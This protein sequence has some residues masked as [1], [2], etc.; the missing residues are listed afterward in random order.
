[1]NYYPFHLG[2]YAVHTR[3]L[4]LLEDLAYRRLL[5]LYYTRERPIPAE[6][7]SVCRLIGMRENEAEV[8]SVLREFFTPNEA[9]EWVSS[10]CEVEIEAFHARAER[11]RENGKQGGRPKKINDLASVV[12]IKNPDETQPVPSGN[13]EGTQSKANQNQNHNQEKPPIPPKGGKSTLGLKAWLDSL[14]ASGEKPIPPD[15][16]VFAYA[17][18]VGIPHDFLRLAWLEFRHQHTQPNAKRYKDWRAHFRNAVRK[19]WGRLWW[20]DPASNTYQL[21]T[22]GQQAQRAHTEKNEKAEKTKEAA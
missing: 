2:D 19:N 17:D 16:A 8:E 7:Q 22:V 14:K 20:I 3:H 4:T 5:D 1:V 13:P 9:G 21:T 15:D 10:R 6:T 11:A 12:P 18:E